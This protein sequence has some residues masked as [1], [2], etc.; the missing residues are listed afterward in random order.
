MVFKNIA[1]TDSFRQ[2]LSLAFFGCILRVNGYSDEDKVFEEDATFALCEGIRR[3]HAL[4]ARAHSR[5]QR[6]GGDMQDTRTSGPIPNLPSEATANVMELIGALGWLASI[7]NDAVIASS[8]GDICPMDPASRFHRS[9]DS[10]SE[11]ELSSPQ[12]GSDEDPDRAIVM[13]AQSEGQALMAFWGCGP[14]NDN[15]EQTVRQLGSLVIVLFKKLASFIWDSKQLGTGKS[16]YGQTQQHY[17][18]TLKLAEAWRSAFGTWDDATTTCFRQAPAGIRRIVAFC[19]TDGELAV[20]LLYDAA[21]RLEIE[22]AQQPSAPGKKRLLDALRS[23]RSN[24]RDQRLTSAVQISTL[25]SISLGVTS[26]GFDGKS[27]LKA[28]V[29]DIGAHPV[30]GTAH[31]SYIPL[32]TE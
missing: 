32:L 11:T 8:H 23:S 30:S 20:L 12:H 31:S 19:L 7:V 25:A 22:L 5:L 4:C 17:E 21:R 6:A 1:A 29:Q 24:L 26:P 3:L 15:L 13:R 16:S 28:S 14:S 2:S 18:T 10:P 27:G 9:R